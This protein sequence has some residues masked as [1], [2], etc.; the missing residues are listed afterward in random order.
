VL[1][2]AVL[3]LGNHPLGSVADV[4]P[5]AFLLKHAGGQ[6]AW[7]ANWLIGRSKADRLLLVSEAWCLEPRGPIATSPA[8]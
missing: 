3:A 6:Q 1:G 8:A 5:A 7:V 4:S 2:Q